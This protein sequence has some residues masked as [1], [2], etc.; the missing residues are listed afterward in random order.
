MLS[1]FKIAQQLSGRTFGWLLAATIVGLPT[2]QPQRSVGDTQPTPSQHTTSLQPQPAETPLQENSR[3][4]EISPSSGVD[5]APEGWRLTKYGWERA[6]QWPTSL[7]ATNGT[8]INALINQ[9]ESAESSM[10]A[11]QVVERS[12]RLVRA[13]NPVTLVA[14]EVTLLA[15]L[16]ALV[17]H[18]DSKRAASRQF[19]SR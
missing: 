17:F 5:V 19:T 4:D 6:E 16:V 14:L 10:F 9:Q 1:H 18:R 3:D 8:N 7:A 2:P 13:L 15:L 12:M 11:G